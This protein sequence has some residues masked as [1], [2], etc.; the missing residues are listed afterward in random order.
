[1]VRSHY[2]RLLADSALKIMTAAFDFFSD[3]EMNATCY[4]VRMTALL[5]WSLNFG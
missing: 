4:Q 2:V 3:F 5:R 1:M